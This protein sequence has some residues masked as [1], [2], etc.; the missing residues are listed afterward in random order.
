MPWPGCTS[1]GK[2]P[3][4]GGGSC[5]SGRAPCLALG[6]GRGWEGPGVGRPETWSSCFT[7]VGP[8]GGLVGNSDPSSEEVGFQATSFSFSGPKEDVEGGQ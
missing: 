7:H 5:W 2:G 8:G 6:L 1:S 3:V 4:K